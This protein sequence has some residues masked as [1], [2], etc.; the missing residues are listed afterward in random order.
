MILGRIIPA[1]RALF[2]ANPLTAITDELANECDLPHMLWDRPALFDPSS[3]AQSLPRLY[4]VMCPFENVIV[5]RCLITFRA[6]PIVR[7]ATP[8][9]PD[10]IIR[11]A[12]SEIQASCQMFP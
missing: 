4:A 5:F 7:R 1:F 10:L 6:S 3:Y 12:W 9:P 11:I 2:T 8:H